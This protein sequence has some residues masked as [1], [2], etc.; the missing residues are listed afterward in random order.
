MF[1]GVGS[2]ACLRGMRVG[3]CGREW[4]CDGAV[5]CF[6][7]VVGSGVA[8]IHAGLPVRQWRHRSGMRIN[9]LVPGERR[10]EHGVATSRPERTLQ[11]YIK[12]P[13]ST[14]SKRYSDQST[15]I[16]ILTLLQSTRVT[17]ICFMTPLTVTSVLA[18]MAV[19]RKPLGKKAH[20]LTS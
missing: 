12:F 20:T 10:S 4:G 6:C 19:A 17:I 5:D 9:E 8:Q 1:N 16:N 11:N 15:Y 2:R 7:A 13:N 3:G 14:S 18:D